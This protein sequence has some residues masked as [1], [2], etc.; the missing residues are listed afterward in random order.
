MYI[1]LYIMSENVYLIHIAMFKLITYIKLWSYDY[2]GTT[3][4]IIFSV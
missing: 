3:F 1:V 2:P 4:K